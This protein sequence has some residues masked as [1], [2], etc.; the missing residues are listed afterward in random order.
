MHARHRR[1]FAA[2]AGSGTSEKRQNEIFRREASFA[3]ESAQGG[4]SS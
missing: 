1:D 2:H 4:G 3:D